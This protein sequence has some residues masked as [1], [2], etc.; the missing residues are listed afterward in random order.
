MGSEATALGANSPAS[1]W[2][3]IAAF[4]EAGS[5][6]STVMSVVDKG[7][8]VIVVDDGSTDGTSEIVEELPVDRVRHCINLG[9]GAALQT[10]ILHALDRGAEYIVTFDAD[11]QHRAEDIEP[12][13]NPL[14]EG[15]FDITLGSRFL[16]G[17]AGIGMPRAKRLTLKLALALTRC[18]VGLK[19]TDVHNGLRGMTAETAQKIRIT[20]NGMAHASQ[21]LS[22]I[23]RLGLRYVEVPVTI[24]YTPY[25]IAKGQRISNAFHILWDSISEV[26]R[27]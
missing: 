17:G 1:A 24:H 7:Y 13:L 9:Q 22:E 15:K 5:I 3:V 12:I 6:R 26:F 20:Q 19:L 16:A 8:G 2:V 10:G 4:N 14:R 23:K 18:T 21:I 25:S 11:G 27:L